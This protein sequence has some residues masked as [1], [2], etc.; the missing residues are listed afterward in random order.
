MSESQTLG[1][2][3]RPTWR[4]K[5]LDRECQGPLKSLS[6]SVGQQETPPTAE[7]QAAERAKKQ[8]VVAKACGNTSLPGPLKPLTRRDDRMDEDEEDELNED[9]EQDG[10]NQEGEEGEGEEP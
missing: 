3:R 4:L 2:A 5:E 6:K 10:L 8:A 9:G 7:S 1:R